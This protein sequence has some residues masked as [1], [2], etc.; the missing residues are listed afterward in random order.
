MSSGARREEALPGAALGGIAV[1][2]S[3]LLFRKRWGEVL[4]KIGFLPELRVDCGAVRAVA[5]SKG[6]QSIP[7]AAY[8]HRG[9]SL[10]FQEGIP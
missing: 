1:S 2:I 5:I 6:A 9:E 10:I 4:E 3:H 7:V 8:C